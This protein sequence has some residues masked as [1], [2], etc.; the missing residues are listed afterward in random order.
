MVVLT[1]RSGKPHWAVTAMASPCDTAGASVTDGRCADWC[2]ASITS[3]FGRAHAVEFIS[4]T[5]Y[6]CSII[7]AVPASTEFQVRFAAVPAEARK[8]ITV[9]THFHSEIARSIVLAFRTNTYTSVWNN[10][11]RK[12]NNKITVYIIYNNTC[13][14]YIWGKVYLK[15][16]ML[17]VA[18]VNDAVNTLCKTYHHFH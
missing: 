2:P 13:I 4:D 6:T 5:I 11:I 1:I 15:Y 9:V 14:W 10:G 7:I 3:E 17:L 8:A 16:S 12:K 18:V